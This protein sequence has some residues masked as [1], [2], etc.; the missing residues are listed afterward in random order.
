MNV[1]DPEAEYYGVKVYVLPKCTCWNPTTWCNGIGVGGWDGY[2]TVVVQLLSHVQFFVTPCMPKLPCPSACQ[3]S[4]SFSISRSLLKP[5]SIESVMPSNHLDLFHSLLQK[6]SPPRNHT[7]V[8]S[9][10][11]RFF[12]F[13]ATREVP[14]IL[15]WRIPWTEEP[16][17][18]VMVSQSQ[19][20]QSDWA[21]A[22][23]QTTE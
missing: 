8:S 22:L 2:K 3:A 19:P 18:L 9:I 7:G 6:I 12:T 1:G 23:I 17:G 14:R 10:A 15:A 21:C 4:L 20:Q 13:W 5:M 11:G 16:G